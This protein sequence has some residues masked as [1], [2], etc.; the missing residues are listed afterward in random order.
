MRQITT[1]GAVS[2]STAVDINTLHQQQLD[3][4]HQ[5]QF[6]QPSNLGLGTDTVYKSVTKNLQGDLGYLAPFSGQI[7]SQFYYHFHFMM[8][9][10][11][12]DKEQETAA[13]NG[14]V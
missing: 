5:Q 7:K 12:D 6:R 1:G 11:L 8:H 9:P 10:M 14:I 13:I 3:H 2:A 4:I